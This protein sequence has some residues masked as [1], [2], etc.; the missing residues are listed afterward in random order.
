L[1]MY[2]PNKMPLFSPSGQAN[3][4]YDPISLGEG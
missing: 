4:S 3:S 1:G 2:I